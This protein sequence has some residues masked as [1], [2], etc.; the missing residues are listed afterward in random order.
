MQNPITV[1]DKVTIEKLVLTDPQ[2]VAAVKSAESDGRDLGEY[3]VQA[4]EIGIKALLATGVSIGVEVLAEGI[5]QSKTAMTRASKQFEDEINARIEAM[6]GKE[7]VLPK[8]VD[9]QL[10]KFAEELGKLTG[11]EKSPIREGI[12]KQLDTATKKLADDFDRMTRGQKEEMF[13]LLDTSNPA[14]PLKGIGDDLEA[15]SDVLEVVRQQ[16]TKEA[17]VA[18]IISESPEGGNKY[19]DVAI[20]AMQI[21]AGWAGDEC[22][23]VGDVTGRVPRS[24]MGDGVVDLKVGATV[25]ARIAVECKDSDLSKTEWMKEAAGSKANRAATGFIGLCKEVDDM[26]SRNRMVVLDA[27]SIVLAYDPAKDDP[28]ILHL[29]YQVVKLNTLRATGNLEDI[30]MAEINKQLEDA[31]EALK[32]FDNMSRQMKAIENS[33]LALRKDAKEIRETMTN[34]ISF[35]RKSIAKGIEPAELES[36]KQL[37]LETVDAEIEADEDGE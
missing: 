31:L 1:T 23:A 26:P 10:K 13:K 21:I 25:F 22:E 34:N 30:D 4:I 33:V 37:E 14:S 12:Q 15:M 5:E 36:A 27:Q 32:R 3:I 28:Q 11:G 29:V 19:E 24:K 18:E 35:V 8:A 6:V 20:G 16:V 7:G 9:A 2:V 17:V